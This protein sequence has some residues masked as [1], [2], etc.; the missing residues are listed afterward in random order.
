M[1][2]KNF[3]EKDLQ[4]IIKDEIHSKN[5]HT[6]MIEGFIKMNCDEYT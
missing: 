6:P 5:Y 1:M 3:N 4:K 2:V